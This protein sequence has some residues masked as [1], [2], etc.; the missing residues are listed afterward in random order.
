MRYVQ[1]TCAFS[2]LP[3]AAADAM[4]TEA[5]A[6]GRVAGPRRAG[7]A[8][9]ASP[10]KAACA[11]ARPSPPSRR[12]GAAA[13]AAELAD[14]TSRRPAVPPSTCALPLLAHATRP[15]VYQPGVV[16]LCCGFLARASVPR[17]AQ[18]CACVVV[19][20]PSICLCP[21]LPAP[22]TPA[23]AAS[24]AGAALSITASVVLPSL[25]PSFPLPYPPLSLITWSLRALRGT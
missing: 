4:P 16:A 23:T 13:R 19:P 11:P 18:G 21:C 5:P 7:G 10:R 12:R 24:V 6:C 2:T 1:Y 17:R 20:T 25:P 8:L 9:A 14:A 22:R 15:A 3:Q